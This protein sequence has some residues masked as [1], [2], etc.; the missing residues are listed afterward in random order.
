MASKAMSDPASKTIEELIA[1]YTLHPLLCDVYVEG[2]TDKDFIRWFLDR[3][4]RLTVAVYPITRLNISGDLLVNSGAE[5]NNRTRVIFLAL[6]LERQLGRLLRVSC[7]ADADFDFVLAIP[8]KA[9]LLLL[10]D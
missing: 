4:G 3:C 2:E 9:A 7:I 10:T 6:T 1:R 8:N 5:N